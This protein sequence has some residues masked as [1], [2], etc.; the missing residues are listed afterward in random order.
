MFALSGHETSQRME[1]S[2]RR[3]EDVT[4]SMYHMARQTARDSSSMHVITF[5]TLVFLPGTFLGV[6]LLLLPMIMTA[7]CPT[8]PAAGFSTS[9]TCDQTFFST[10]ILSTSPDAA[11]PQSWGINRGLLALFFKICIPMMFVTVIIWYLYLNKR[12]FRRVPD[13]YGRDDVEASAG[14]YAGS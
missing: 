4:D 7:L 1:D 9:L 14:K 2:A 11:D 12:W 10:P 3:M 13:R 8:P 5:F 6:R